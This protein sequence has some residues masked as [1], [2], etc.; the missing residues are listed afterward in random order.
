MQTANE[1][2]DPSQ[3]DD[4]DQLLYRMP[5]EPPPSDLATR[6][7][8]QIRLRQR[9][10]QGVRLGLSLLL[11]VFGIWLALPGLINSA[12]ELS[13]PASGFSYFNPLV[14]SFLSGLWG[15][16]Q[17]TLNSLSAFQANLAQTMGAITWLGMVALASAALLALSLVMPQI[18]Q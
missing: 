16:T 3:A 15:F 7:C 8:H 9:H 1:F 17:N 12:E 4:L 5:G 14:Q 13:L 11:A 10:A 18:E 6:I 2:E